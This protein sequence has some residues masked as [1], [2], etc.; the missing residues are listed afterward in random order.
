MQPPRVP[1]LD[2]AAHLGRL[3][4]TAV[5]TVLV[6]AMIGLAATQ[7]LMR[8]LL[9]SGFSW[10][11]E[12]LRIMVLWVTMAGAVAASGERR[13]VSIDVLSRYLPRTW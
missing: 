8:N 6:V 5:L 2:R 9:G 10:A 7:I 3:V 4:E 11:D 12:A 1:W 13:H